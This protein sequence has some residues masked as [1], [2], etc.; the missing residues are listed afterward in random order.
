MEYA[1]NNHSRFG[2][3][4]LLMAISSC[5]WFLGVKRH[6]M[7]IEIV[8]GDKKRLAEINSQ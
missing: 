6:F 3:K 5:C 1:I 4:F 7:K 2:C 8:R